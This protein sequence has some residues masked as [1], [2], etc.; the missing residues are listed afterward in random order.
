LS[1]YALENLKNQVTTSLSLT[2]MKGLTHTILY[3]YSDR[4][5][6]DDYSIVDTKLTY[7]NGNILVF[8]EIS[9]LLDQKYQETN[10]VIMPGRWFRIGVGYTFGNG[11]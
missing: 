5:N 10:L 6:L 3:R 11:L 7:D 8:G 1:K 2:Y 9:N 4:V